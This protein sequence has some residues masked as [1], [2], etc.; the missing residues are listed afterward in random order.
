VFSDYECHALSPFVSFLKYLEILRERA[1]A[2]WDT[3]A[4]CFQQYEL[5][6]G[7]DLVGNVGLMR[8][9]HERVRL[10]F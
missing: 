9:G 7:S 4:A 10:Q 5:N 8:F 6:E 3:A 2:R 1:P